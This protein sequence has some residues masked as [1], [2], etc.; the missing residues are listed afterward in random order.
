M[1]TSF[2][3]ALSVLSAMITPAVLI[4]GCG[5]LIIATTARL[6]GAVQRT[7]DLAA[8]FAAVVERGTPE[9]DEAVRTVLFQQLDF[10]TSRSRMLQRGLTRLYW[11]LGTFVTTSVTIGVVAVT[12]SQYAWLPILFGLAGAALLLYACIVLVRESGVA[13]A[14]LDLEM[15]HVWKTGRSL[16]T[17]ELMA[18]R[19]AFGAFGRRIPVQDE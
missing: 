5:S 2:P 12:G 18:Q 15:D 9:E 8:E 14:A 7:R 10:S 4:S 1:A 16:A 6:D 17:P 19:K 11:A 3:D 13:V